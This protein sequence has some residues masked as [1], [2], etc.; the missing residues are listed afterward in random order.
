MR[1]RRLRPCASS[2]GLV[3]ELIVNLAA[4]Y[5]LVISHVIIVS[6]QKAVQQS[7]VFTIVSPLGMHSPDFITIW[8]SAKYL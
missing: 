8:G 7:I 2:R 6:T 1:G 5:M 4:I 3:D